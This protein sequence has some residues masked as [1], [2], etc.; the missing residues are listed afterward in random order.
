[1]LGVTE[2]IIPIASAMVD[3]GV[4]L[5]AVLALILKYEATPLIFDIAGRY[6]EAVQ[7]GGYVTPERFFF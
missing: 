1:M 7:S 6:S 4:R 3:K 5:E 2:I